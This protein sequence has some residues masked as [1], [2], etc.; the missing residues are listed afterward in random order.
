MV[1]SVSRDPMSEDISRLNLEFLRLLREA[2][3]ANPAE[4]A[5]RFGVSDRLVRSVVSMSG[6]ELEE[7][8]RGGLAVFRV[9]VATLPDTGAARR[10]GARHDRRPP[11]E[12]AA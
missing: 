3:R 1:D 8:A 4:C 2:G 12:I 11:R 7:L 5:L 9:E 10:S 6:F